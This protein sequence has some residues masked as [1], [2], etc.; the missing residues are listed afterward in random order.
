VPGVIAFDIPLGSMFK[1]QVVELV[2]I[3]KGDTLT[4]QAAC[5]IMIL[6]FVLWGSV[7]PG[8]DIRSPIRRTFSI[9]VLKSFLEKSDLVS[10]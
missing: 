3:E 1:N 7:Y 10:K 4:K 9:G 5:R 2:S 6:S 8:F